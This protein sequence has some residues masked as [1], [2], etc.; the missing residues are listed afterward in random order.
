MACHLFWYRNYGLY[1]LSPALGSLFVKFGQGIR[2]DQAS[3]T[4]DLNGQ[5]V[6]D[7]I[8]YDERTG[9]RGTFGEYFGELSILAW[10]IA[11]AIMISGA[12]KNVSLG[13][14]AARIVNL[15]TRFE[16][17][18]GL[19]CRLD[20]GNG[21]LKWVFDKLVAEGDVDDLPDDPGDLVDFLNKYLPDADGDGTCDVL[22]DTP[23]GD[24]NNNGVADWK[25]EGWSSYAAK[26]RH[27]QELLRRKIKDYFDRFNNG[28]AKRKRDAQM[29]MFDDWGHIGAPIPR[30]GYIFPVDG[31]GGPDLGG[32]FGDRFRPPPGWFPGMVKPVYYK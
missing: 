30:Y 31:I 14:L 18:H 25:D 9:Y 12:S 22:D 4:V 6:S 3:N 29:D 13:K 20:K 8:L 27:E 26:K 16:D 28:H 10:D 7:V 1:K 2:Y 17:A 21:C 15:I 32:G 11:G 19:G 24:Q 5:K 23:E